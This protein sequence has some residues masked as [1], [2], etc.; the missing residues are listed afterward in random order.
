MLERAL[1]L[2][3]LC[4]LLRGAE[5]VLLQVRGGEGVHGDARSGYQALQ[6]RLPD[7]V[8]PPRARSDAHGHTGTFTQCGK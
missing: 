6:V 8:I 7:P 4:V 1:N 5:G 2:L 3:L